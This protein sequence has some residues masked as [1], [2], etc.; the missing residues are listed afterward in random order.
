VAARI[1]AA[2]DDLHTAT[3]LR[4]LIEI[5]GGEIRFLAKGESLADAWRRAPA[6]LVLLDE[7]QGVARA[8]RLRQ[9]EAAEGA[10]RA[11]VLLLADNPAAL[12][13]PEVDACLAHP[14]QADALYA[15]VE[16]L[17]AAPTPEKAS[18]A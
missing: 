12:R 6:D 14:I 16:R 1:L 9:A 17:S 8:R 4:A 18:A 11:P 3:V 10:A 2:V 5:A 15:A 7:A 13:A